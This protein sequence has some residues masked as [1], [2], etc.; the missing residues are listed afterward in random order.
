[1]IDYATKC[2]SNSAGPDRLNFMCASVYELPFEDG[3]VDGVTATSLAGCLSHPERFYR[4][5]HRVLR[6]GGHLVM[7]FTNRSSRLLKLNARL[8]RASSGEGHGQDLS[9]ACRLYRSE[10]V[11][12]ELHSVGFEVVG[13]RYYNFF[14]N[15]GDAL[16]PPRAIAL[17]LERF[18]RRRMGRR[19]GRNFVV[20]ACKM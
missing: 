19:L 3:A 6:K 2:F 14:L 16:I 15:L 13:V 5:A 12:E 18:G 8:R 7:T 20:A 17:Y 4:E 1:M 9:F 10:R 11:T